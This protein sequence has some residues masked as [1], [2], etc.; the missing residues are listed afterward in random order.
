MQLG[1]IFISGIVS[2]ASRALEVRVPG[3]LF[4]YQ[5]ISSTGVAALLPGG[6][7][8]ACVSFPSGSFMLL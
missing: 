1:S 2:L 6:I 5:A 3:Q 7:M 8:R 4:C